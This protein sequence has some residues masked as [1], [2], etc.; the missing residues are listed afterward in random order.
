M[1]RFLVNILLVLCFALPSW[2]TEKQDQV[3]QHYR[4]IE[5]PGASMEQIMAGV[6]AW[7]AAKG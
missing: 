7:D 1:C 2:S 5:L 6:E 4:E 3:W